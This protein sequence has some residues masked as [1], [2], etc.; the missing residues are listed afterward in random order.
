[1]ESKM[2]DDLYDK[3]LRKLHA[4]RNRD[5]NYQSAKSDLWAI[6]CDDPERHLKM[7][8]ANWFNNN[9]SRKEP[10]EYAKPKAPTIKPYAPRPQKSEADL[11]AERAVATNR[12]GMALM[13]GYLPDGETRLK[14]ATGAQLKKCSGFF[15]LLAKHVRPNQVTGRV[16]TAE[17][18]ANLWNREH[19]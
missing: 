10:P 3:L 11:K 18:I 12:L 17:Q 2:A 4:A 16:L 1:M 9:W 8:F 7:F 15:A 13:N 19:T 5:E 14:D 6:V